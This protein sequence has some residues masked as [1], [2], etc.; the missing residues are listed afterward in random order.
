MKQTEQEAVVAV[1]LGLDIAKAKFDAQVLAHGKGQHKVFENTPKGFEALLAWLKKLDIERVHACLEASGG[2]GDALAEFLYQ[3]KHVISIVNPTRIKG[4]A[5]SQMRRHK[6]DRLDAEVIRDFC[7]KHRPAAWQPPSPESKAL[8]ELVRCYDAELQAQ[9]A[10][11]NRLHSPNISDLLKAHLQRE[12]DFHKQQLKT[13]QQHIKALFEQHPQLARQRDLLV[14][15]PGIGA[16]TATTLL[17]EI[18]DVSR[19]DSARSLAANIGVTP[20]ERSSGTSTN[21]KPRMSKVGNAR[22]RAALWWPAV[23]AMRHN[24]IVVAFIKRLRSTHP[25]GKVLI[26]AAMHKLM[27]LA[28]GVLNNDRPFTPDWLSGSS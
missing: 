9:S 12:L 22:L 26:V 25:T 14:S 8:R 18:M 23:Q 4:H 5:L 10:C 16:R 20:R 21:A 2:Y 19:F 3:A 11:K 28:Y 13:L 15:I 1:A 24:P 6:N 7:D 27:H 17:A